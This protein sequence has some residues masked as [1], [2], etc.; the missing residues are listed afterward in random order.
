M[1]GLPGEREDEVEALVVD[2][3][4][5]SL[6]ARRPRDV[7]DVPADLEATAQ[8][9]IRA[10]PRYHPSFRFEEHLAARLAAAAAETPGEGRIVPFTRTSQL[11][12]PGDRAGLARPVVIGS[13]VTSAAISL[14]GAAFVAWRLARPGDPMSRAV[15]A[16]GRT[17]LA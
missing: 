12:D 11:G 2:R 7:A 1:T 8:T 3:Y 15:R 10:L 13:V 6:L 9:L 17:R 4:L 14:A 16:V 5:E